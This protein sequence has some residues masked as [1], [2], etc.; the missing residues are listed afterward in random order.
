MQIEIEQ[1]DNGIRKV[2]LIG[3]LD[4]LGVQAIDMRFTA[5]TAT[6]AGLVLVDLSQLSFLASLGM[7]T[8]ISSAKALSQ[9]GGRM[10]IVDPQPN[11]REVMQV[12]GLS[13][14]IPVYPNVGE[15]IQALVDFKSK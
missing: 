5:L 7:R 14:L 15:G 12:S 13:S 8:L 9:R 6:Q 11:V 4:M 3:R 10:V 2:R 1:L